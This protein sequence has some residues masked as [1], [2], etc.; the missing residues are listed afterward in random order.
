[1]W[2]AVSMIMGFAAFVSRGLRW[3][4]LIKSMG[5]KASGLNCVSAVTVGYF[6]NLAIPRIGEI[7]RCTSLNQVEE[8]PVNK[9]F[10]TILLERT[11]DM[12]ILLSLVAAAFILQ[13][14]RIN[15]F[16]E[17]AMGSNSGESSNLKFYALGVGLLMVF[18]FFLFRS[19]LRRF[20]LYQK[21]VNFLLGLKEGFQSIS[22]MENKW[23][24][25][26]HTL[27]IWLMYFAMTF[28]CIYALPETSHLSP[29][30]GL[31]LMV[32]GGLGMV[33]PAQ[34]GI[35][36]YHYA[37]ILGMVALGIPKETGIGLTY[38]TIVHAAQTIMI[39]ATGGLAVLLLYL[40][41]RKKAKHEAI[42]N[43]GV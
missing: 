11:I 23:A 19:R 34:G 17:Q 9:L 20:G 27:F 32:A 7:T 3:V 6:A 43:T 42:T 26:V 13:F 35:G 24:F 25:W 2:V 22:K 4:I 39:L 16:F 14:D 41:R 31:I 10:G 18:L 38:A 36:S 15:L 12:L 1:M 33:V 8:V 29:A 30:D 37:I 28:V 40:A 21:V 5:Y